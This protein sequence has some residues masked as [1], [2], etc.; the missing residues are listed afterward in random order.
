MMIELIEELMVENNKV[1]FYNGLDFD[2]ILNHPRDGS[3]GL[4]F[5]FI[6]KWQNEIVKYNRNK[7]LNSIFHGSNFE[8]FNWKEIDNDYV[9]IYQIQGT[10]NDSVYK[11]IREKL[12][13][14]QFP[15]LWVNVSG[16]DS[17]AWKIT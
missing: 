17:G 14:G 9:F 15:Q 2:F 8:E 3:E 7:K 6:Q 4:I 11:T 13:R 12:L 5:F 16:L 1:R 10:D